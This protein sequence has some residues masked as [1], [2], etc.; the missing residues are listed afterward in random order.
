LVG[1]KVTSTTKYTGASQIEGSQTTDSSSSSSTSPPLTF[2]KT[3]TTEWNHIIHF[4]RYEYSRSDARTAPVESKAGS[5][6]S[7]PTPINLQVSYNADWENENLGVLGNTLSG[8]AANIYNNAKG[9]GFS[10]LKDAVVQFGN[11]FTAEKGKDL[12][13]AW[14]LDK[15]QDFDTVY[16][17]FSRVTGLAVNPYKAVL[18]RSP[19]FRSF[20]FSYK[21][22]PSNQQEADTIAAI[23]KEFKYGMH[24]SFDA[25]FQDNVFKYPDVWR[26]TIGNGD[27][28]YMFKILT[29][30]LRNVTYNPH[31]EGTKSYIR[32][33][34]GL[35][36]PLSV[37]LDLEFQ[38]L[39]I[40]TKEDISKGY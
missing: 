3:L 37:T 29:C 40:L 23:V 32:T 12:L 27:D 13:Q 16:N 10:G 6:I 8:D 15:A 19:D 20:Q 38:E 31:G 22:I 36:I 5:L 34:S 1:T 39:S 11:E 2:P 24:P 9:K 14:A 4:Q 17:T 25:A 18:Y 30:A 26:I 21:F 7:L 35:N 33:D 28:K